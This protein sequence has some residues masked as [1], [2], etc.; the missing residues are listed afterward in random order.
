MF[1]RVHFS[2]QALLWHRAF[3]Q[4]IDPSGFS[5]MRIRTAE[6]PCFDG[7]HSQAQSGFERRLML[8][9]RNLLP[10]FIYDAAQLAETAHW[11]TL[12]WRFMRR[13]M[14]RRTV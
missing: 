5:N 12:V 10:H 8:S 14:R 1:H 13:Q 4:S 9:C 11:I 3:F 2:G 7:R 6:E